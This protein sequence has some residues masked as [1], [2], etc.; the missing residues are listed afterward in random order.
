M[1]I[2][3]AWC[4]KALGDIEVAGVS[5][6]VIS[7][8]ICKECLEHFSKNDHSFRSYLNSFDLPIFAIDSE[9]KVLIANEES[10]RLLGKKVEEIENFKGGDAMECAYARLP[11]GCGNTYHCKT[12]TIRNSVMET[13]KTGKNAKSNLGTDRNFR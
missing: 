5:E 11:G 4:E 8:G 3:C 12:C 9:G 7:H 1:K 6:K 13:F 10:I 2:I